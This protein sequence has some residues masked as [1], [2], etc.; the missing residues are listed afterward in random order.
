M[1][2]YTQ[3]HDKGD[4]IYFVHDSTIL[5]REVKDVCFNGEFHYKVKINAF[6]DLWISEEKCFKYLKGMFNYYHTR[7]DK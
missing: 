5:K 1:K 2:T 4:V 6:V 3:R 7:L